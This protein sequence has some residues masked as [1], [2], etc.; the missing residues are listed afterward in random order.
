MSFP[1]DYEQVE[2]ELARK[3]LWADAWTAVANASDCKSKNAPTTWADQAL[4]DF[5]KR[6]PK[7]LIK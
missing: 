4:A 2:H 5:D 6:F 7:P 3:K 1:T